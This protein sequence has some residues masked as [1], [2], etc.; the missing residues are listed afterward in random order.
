MPRAD[1][2]WSA[3]PFLRVSVIP[4]RVLVVSKENRKL[5]GIY[6]KEKKKSCRVPLSRTL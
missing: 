2:L 4:D 5:E 6:L 3:L 1:L